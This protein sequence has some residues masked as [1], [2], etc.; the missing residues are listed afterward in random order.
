MSEKQLMF[1]R[2]SSC[3][4][5]AYSLIR[6]HLNKEIHFNVANAELETGINRAAD[7]LY[8]ISGSKIVLQMA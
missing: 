1:S 8:F 3:S 6:R 5:E 4:Q 2:S 7:E